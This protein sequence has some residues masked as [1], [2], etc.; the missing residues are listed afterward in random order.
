MLKEI[1][2]KYG[3]VYIHMDDA[4]SENDFLRQAAAEGFLFGDGLNPTEKASSDFFAIHSDRTINFIN[5][6]GRIACQAH[7]LTTLEYSQLKQVHTN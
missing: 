2:E 1:A 4:D 7:G 3:T 6:I 5:S